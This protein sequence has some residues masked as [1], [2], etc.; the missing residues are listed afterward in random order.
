MTRGAPP[1]KQLAVAEIQAIADKVKF[2]LEEKFLVFNAVEFKSQ[3]VAGR[4]FFIKVQMDDDFVHI[5]M[6]ESLLQENKSVALTSYQT[7]K[8]RQ[9]EVMCF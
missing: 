7:H 2:P 3:G 1:A 4:T 9:D 5:Q 8:G 6:F